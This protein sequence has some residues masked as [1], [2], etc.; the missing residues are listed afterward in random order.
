MS[1]IP[2]ITPIAYVIMLS[3]RCMGALSCTLPMIFE[4]LSTTLVLLN[5]WKSVCA[6]L[7]DCVAAFLTDNGIL[8]MYDPP[9]S[10]ESLAP[11]SS[12]SESLAPVP[13]LPAIKNDDPP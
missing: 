5:F 4:S 8:S 9:P 1:C 6:L 12:V 2:D 10:L 7:P 11:L 3:M 13:V